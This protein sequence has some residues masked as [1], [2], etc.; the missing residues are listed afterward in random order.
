MGPTGQPASSR[1][2]DMADLYTA[3]RAR[4]RSFVAG[5][6][7]SSCD[8]DDIVQEAFV[9]LLLAGQT[10]DIENPASFLFTAARNLAIDAARY[11]AR[12]ATIEIGSYD[13]DGIPAGPSSEA[14]LDAYIQL[15]E[16]SDTIRRFPD[17][18]RNLFLRR[19]L[20]GQSY[21]EISRDT[22]I[23]ISTIEKHVANCVDACR[24]RAGCN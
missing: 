2:A 14:G 9:R 21:K 16:L 3:Q 22:R 18:S 11:R 7:G 12:R 1:P 10:I 6:A 24:Q 19:K 17:K 4:L 20:L 8:V 15:N 23:A 13:E 5:F